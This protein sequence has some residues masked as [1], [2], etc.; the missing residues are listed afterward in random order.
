M[1]KEE[2]KNL[3]ID[4]ICEYDFTLWSNDK[5]YNKYTDLLFEKFTK[6]RRNLNEIY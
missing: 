1:T 3:L 6:I 5:V 4:F 2:I